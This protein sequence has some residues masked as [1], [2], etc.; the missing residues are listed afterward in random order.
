[1]NIYA[2][3]LP[4][5]QREAITGRDALFAKTKLRDGKEIGQAEA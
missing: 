5:V 1:M 2:H 4:Q 3:V